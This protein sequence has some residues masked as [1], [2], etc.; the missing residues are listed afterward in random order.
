M[1]YDEIDVPR[2]LPTLDG[3]TLEPDGF[4]LMAQLIEENRPRVIVEFGSGASTTTLAYLAE[5]TGGNFLSIEED[6][7]WANRT[8]RRLQSWGIEG[9]A[10]HHVPVLPEDQNQGYTWYSIEGVQEVLGRLDIDLVLVD[11]PTAQHGRRVRDATLPV[12]ADWLSDEAI[13]VFDDYGREGESEFL[14]EYQER[15]P[16]SS[17]DV[18]SRHKEMAVFRPNGEL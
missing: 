4:L 6:A 2:P 15:F 10:V 7:E 11:G 13:V 18:I 3:W 9:A 12:I 1:I 8:R 5:K 17:T 16:E 14:A